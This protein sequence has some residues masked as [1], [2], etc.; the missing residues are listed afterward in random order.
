MYS[1][2]HREMGRKTVPKLT[3][4]S[5]KPDGKFEHLTM[6]GNDAPGPGTY[7][8]RP[9]LKNV[10]LMGIFGRSE[11]M[12]S[13]RSVSSEKSDLLAP[14]EAKNPVMR[15]SAAYGFGTSRRP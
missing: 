13:A 1:I 11:R 5:E 3:L 7:T 4:I 15:K 12:K 9:V 8:A 2:G 14:A 6:V 10:N